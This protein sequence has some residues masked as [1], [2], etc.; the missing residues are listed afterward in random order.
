M[1]DII[2]LLIVYFF[3]QNSGLLKLTSVYSLKYTASFFFTHN[4][5]FK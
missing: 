1:R 2:F 3:I 5:N 4:K